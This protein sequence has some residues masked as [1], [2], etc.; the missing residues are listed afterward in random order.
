MEGTGTD[1]KAEKETEDSEDLEPWETW[2]QQ[3][4]TC[5]KFHFLQSSQSE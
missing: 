5:C 2:N 1:G 3:R 4:I